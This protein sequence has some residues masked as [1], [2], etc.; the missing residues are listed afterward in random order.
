MGLQAHAFFPIRRAGHD[1][2]HDRASERQLLGARYLV[3]WPGVVGDRRRA[4]GGPR[5]RRPDRHGP[6]GAE[7][8]DERRALIAIE[9]Q[10]TRRLVGR[11]YVPVDHRQSE[12]R[13]KGP[14]LLPAET[15]HVGLRAD[16]YI[17]DEHHCHDSRSSELPRR[18]QD[19]VP[20][21]Q[22]ALCRQLVRKPVRDSWANRRLLRAGSVIGGAGGRAGLARQ[23]ILQWDGIHRPTA[24][25]AC[26]A[27]FSTPTRQRKDTRHRDQR[28]SHV[29]AAR[30]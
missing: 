14:R 22:G 24:G 25:A 5:L 29:G 7:H 11:R 8:P 4:Q 17:S 18:H 15:R 13:V 12:R 23:H 9:Y 16:A 1:Q 20:A 10:G 30:E 21:A 2:G 19:R 6:A 26:R 27:G 3:R 28:H